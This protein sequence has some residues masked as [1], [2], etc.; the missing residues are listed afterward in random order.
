MLVNNVVLILGKVIVEKIID[1]S[2]RVRWNLP[3]DQHMY[4]ISN[5]NIVQ[6]SIFI[7]QY[8]QTNCFP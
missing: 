8:G 1:H 4:I 5:L 3:L 7:Q 6:K 2:S